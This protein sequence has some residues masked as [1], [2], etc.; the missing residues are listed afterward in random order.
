MDEIYQNE[1][2]SNQDDIQYNINSLQDFDPESNNLSSTDNPT[3]NIDKNFQSVQ[4]QQFIKTPKIKL[5]FK[6]SIKQSSTTEPINLKHG[7]LQ[8]NNI[9]IPYLYVP[10]GW[11][12]SNDNDDDNCN[13]WDAIFQTEIINRYYAKPE[14]I[15]YLDECPDDLYNPQ[16]AYRLYKANEVKKKPVSVDV[17]TWRMQASKDR[18]NLLQSKLIDP[19]N[20]EDKA[21]NILISKTMK[22]RLH[23]IIQSISK[24]FVEKGAIYII[25]HHPFK[26]DELI[27]IVDRTLPPAGILLPVFCVKELKDYI[28]DFATDSFLTHAVH[29]DEDIDRTVECNYSLVNSIKN[30]IIFQSLDDKKYFMT[31]IEKK[32]SCGRFCIS[33]N[34]NVLKNSIHS[35]KCGLPLVIFRYTGTTNEIMSQLIE[36]KCRKNN[37]VVK[38]N[39]KTLL[40]TLY[41]WKLIGIA[42]SKNRNTKVHEDDN[43][44]DDN[45]NNKENLIDSLRFDWPEDFNPENVIIIDTLDDRPS[46]IV[47]KIMNAI[48]NDNMRSNEGFSEKYE[49]DESTTSF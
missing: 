13:V 27:D 37:D 34:K 24:A 23:T 5:S 30:M 47:I 11:R 42:S 9:D 38:D 25:N 44:D 35:V 7:I 4:H 20:N 28:D 32:I 12:P 46:D 18:N 31:E 36:S 21:I 43:D 8:S 16:S 3:I 22:S 15:F 45:D 6:S 19:K 17:E 33:D 39:T 48:E 14:F 26:P 41:A 1:T 40:S 29:L 10:T 2:Q 49:R